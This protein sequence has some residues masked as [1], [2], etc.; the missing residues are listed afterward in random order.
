M[1]ANVEVGA[2]RRRR[3]PLLVRITAGLVISL[4]IVAAVGTAGSVSWLKN[5]MREQAPQLDGQLQLPGLS[6]PVLVQRD[7]HG[8]PHIQ[9]ATMDDLLEA[10]G[11]VVAQDRLWQ[12]DMARRFAAGE[13]AELLGSSVVEHDKLQRVLQIRPAAEHLTA[14][15]PRDQKRLFEA[16]ARGVNAYIAAH[17]D[18]LPAEFRLLGYKP[19]PWQPVDSWLVALNM[20]ARLDTL[21]PWKL[22]RAQVEAKLA[23]NLVAQLY[24]TTTWR[25][26]PPT[27]SIPDLTAPQ[28]NIPEVPLDESLSS[29]QDLLR[30]REILNLGSDPCDGCR[31]GSNEWAV[32][33]AHTAS[34]KAMLSND[35]HLEHS[36]PDIWHEEDLQAGSF[37]VAGVTTPGIPLIIEGHNEHISW[38]YT[39]LNGDVQDVYVEKTNSQ[40]D[41]WAGTGWRQ[42]EHDR[43]HIHVRF[44]QDVLLDV[45]TTDHGPVI[46]SLL[47]HETRMLS[48]KWTLYT[49]QLGG[50]PLEAVDAASNWTEFRQAMSQWWG[51]TQNMVYADDQGNI[52]YQAVGLFPLRP[53]GLSGVPIVE[54]GTAADSEHEWQGYIPFSELPSV[55]DP[56]NGIVATANSRITPDGYPYPLALNWDAPYRNERIWKWLSSHTKLTPADMLTLQMDTYSEVDRELAQRFAY[57]IDRVTGADAQLRQAADLMRTWD[58]VITRDSVAAEIVDA[59]RQ[60]LWPLVLE[61]KLG[62]D[63]KLY[64]WQSKNFV[65]EEMVEKAP[66]EWLPAKYKS[67]D[68]LIAAAVHQGMADQHAPP[69]L[70][71]WTY[72]SR[73]VIDVQHPLYG[74]L[75][76]FRSWTSTGPHQLWGDETTLN[77][78]RGLLGASQRLTV[79]WSNVDG[80]TENIVMG[81]SGDP[82]SPYFLDQWPSWYNGKTFAMPF[83]EAAV[84]ASTTHTLRLV[85]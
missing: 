15:M 82:L 35:M 50:L 21:Y 76:F 45:E 85:P 16:F 56:E 47:P 9:A 34:G 13:L 31:R 53:A 52:G 51:P 28:Q 72:G 84:T 67:W 43:E 27:Q 55:L 57:S 48:L 5:A 81:E 29:L 1:M 64:D 39:T 60:A 70:R 46:T 42:P 79:D 3:L 49:T 25:D 23:P 74:M 12:M 66:P 71:D 36:I 40:G 83:T 73:H 41:Y 8:V 58:G 61:P 11:F 4:L 19:R 44:G 68:D 65:Q 63:W 38:G 17:Q 22:E 10:Q 26:H 80:S 59:T 62:S 77:H 37:H 78:V 20:V 2:A 6:A 7:V 24:P 33:G 75:P 14:T 32:S 18:N 69:S 30:L 54:T